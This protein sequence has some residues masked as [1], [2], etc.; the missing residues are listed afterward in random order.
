[1]GMLLDRIKTLI[2]KEGETLPDDGADLLAVSV[3]VLLLEVARA[4]E[5]MTE[6]ERQVMLDRLCDRFEMTRDEAVELLTLSEAHRDES[7]DLFKFTRVI[8]E[9]CSREEKYDVMRELWRVIYADGVLDAHED[10]LAHRF[11]RLLN[12][13]HS[14]FIAAKLDVMKERDS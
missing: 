1:M 14:E 2:A 6:D 12:L 5:R 3:A 10:H 11:G 13:P 8:N 9:R 7:F 4:D